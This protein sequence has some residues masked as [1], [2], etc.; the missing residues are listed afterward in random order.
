VFKQALGHSNNG[1]RTRAAVALHECGD[2]EGLKA[3]TTWVSQAQ[4]NPR[5]AVQ[6]IHALAKIRDAE[7]VQALRRVAREH[8]SVTVMFEGQQR[9]AATDDLI[10]RELLNWR[11]TKG[12]AARIAPSVSAEP[13]RPLGVFTGLTV[14]ERRRL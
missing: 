11:L 14:F 12:Q 9:G 8:G 2:P 6:A 5:G 3:L 13:V 1:T 10:G 4:S 7:S